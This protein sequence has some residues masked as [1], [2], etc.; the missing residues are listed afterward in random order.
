MKIALVHFRAGE[1]DGVSLEMEKWEK[2]LKKMGHEVRYLAGSIGGRNGFT[3]DSMKYDHPENNRLHGMAFEKL[4]VSDG[5]FK[6]ELFDYSKHIKEE[7]EFFFKRWKPDLMIVNNLWS[8]GH[9]LA[10]AIALYEI[11]KYHG[12]RAIGHHHDFFWERERYSNP[13]CDFVSETLEKY[14]PP[15]DDS[16]EHVVINEIAKEVL[17]ERRGIDAF[18]IPNVFDFDRERWKEEPGLREKFG[19]SEEDFIFLHATRIVER[20]AIEIAVDFV[21]KFQGHFPKLADRSVYN[22]R[23]ITKNSRAILFLAGAPEFDDPDYL[24][25]L[26]D[27]A[28]S[29]N[30][31]MV[32]PFK[33]VEYTLWDAYRIT[34]AV[35]YT[36]VKE[37]WGNQFIEAVF[38]KLP[39]IVFEY[40]VFKTDIKKMGFQIFSLGDAYELR[41]GL[42]EIDG[43]IV[44]ETAEK[45]C[46]A[47]VD[48]EK[49]KEKLDENFE[50]GRKFLSLE[51]L[52]DYIGRLID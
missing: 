36:S 48:T 25:R 38:A 47:L 8:L 24:V 30:V 19:M 23:K 18:V 29:K 20:K 46:E 14:F 32:A 35:T 34:D 31:E 28:G 9:N 33:D 6:G 12:I 39:T 52:S 2:V 3:V 26:K 49:M 27:Y 51:A 41:D 13:T 37:G 11:I 4:E 44:G 5:E 10:A 7:I 40:P 17:K 45:F 22:G 1:N 43:G 16:V 42:I 50:I 15:K 21:A